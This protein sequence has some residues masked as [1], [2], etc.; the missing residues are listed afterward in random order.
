[1]S[2]LFLPGPKKAIGVGNWASMATKEWIQSGAPR[3][4]LFSSP[5]YEEGQTKRVEKRTQSG[6]TEDCLVQKPRA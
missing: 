2:R 6:I 1:M 3:I 4:I 5:G